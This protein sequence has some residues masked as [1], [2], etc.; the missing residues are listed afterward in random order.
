MRRVLLVASTCIAVQLGVSSVH[1]ST[2]DAASAVDEIF[3]STFDRDPSQSLETAPAP[4]VVPGKAGQGVVAPPPGPE[5][6]E[7]PP[8][9]VKA[10]PAGAPASS[11]EG[12]AGD[13]ADRSSVVAPKAEAGD[14]AQDASAAAP[15]ARAPEPQPTPA[16][17]QGARRVSST[18]YCLTGTMA[19]GR[20]VYRGAVA[21]NGTPFGSRYQVLDGPRAGETFVVEDRIGRGSSFDIAYP[22]DCRGAMS[23]GR[24]MVT[25]RPV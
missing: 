13:S 22:G 14:R 4:I 7:L 11:Q 21:M 25:I 6:P 2:D 5:P 3:D 17:V 10:E 18:A 24:R 9:V 19:S 12:N 1:A 23:Y 16:T 15:E 20:R 8:V